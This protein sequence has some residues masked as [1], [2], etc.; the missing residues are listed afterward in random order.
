MVSR[1]RGNSGSLGVPKVSSTSNIDSESDGEDGGKPSLDEDGMLKAQPVK[2]PPNPMGAGRKPHPDPKPIASA[3]P[4]QGDLDESALKGLN[5]SQH[6]CPESHPLDQQF[7]IYKAGIFGDG[8]AV[9]A[10][11]PM[12]RSKTKSVKRKTPRKNTEEDEDS[13]FDTL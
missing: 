8:P 2:T 12:Y 3:S 9:D 7:Q 4:F 10:R 6:V 13:V 11:K 5:K 1:T